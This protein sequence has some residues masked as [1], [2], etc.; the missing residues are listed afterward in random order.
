M[1]VYINHLFELVAAIPNPV[2]EEATLRPLPPNPCSSHPCGPNALCSV[3]NGQA[4]CACVANM[5]GTAPNCRPECIIS[6][7]CPSNSACI[8]Q[9]C[10]DPCPGSCSSNAD[11]RVV[12]HSPVCSC[13]QGFQGDGFRD[14]RPIPV[15]GNF[16][17][18]L[19]S[20]SC[21]FG[22]ASVSLIF[23][24]LTH[25]THQNASCCFHLWSY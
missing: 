3:V 18:L 20:D 7:D 22:L 24:R 6:S 16:L 12:N 9:K 17:N 1:H 5:I 19:G 13:T 21:W 14:C 2:V 10:V 11:C 4:D 15:V 23:I 8:N 25:S